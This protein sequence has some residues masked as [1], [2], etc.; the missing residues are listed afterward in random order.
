M[1]MSMTTKYSIP[2]NAV[3]VGLCAGRHDMPV[4]EFIFPTEVDPTDFRAMSRTVDAFLD[5]R[6]GTHISWGPRRNAASVD[7]EDGVEFICGNRPLVV[8]VTG[9]TACIAAVIRG[10]VYNGVDLTLLHYDRTTGKYIPQ[11]VLGRTEPYPPRLS[12]SQG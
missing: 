2:E 12:P 6:V 1:A 4:G 5:T 7:D 11:V 10:C 8:Y 9:L 3:V